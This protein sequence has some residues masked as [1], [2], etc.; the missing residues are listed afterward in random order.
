MGAVKKEKLLLA[1]VFS[2][3]TL[4]DVVQEDDLR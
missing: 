1:G 2:K 4:K 3:T